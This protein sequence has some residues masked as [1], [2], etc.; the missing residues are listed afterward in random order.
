[1]QLKPGTA[2]EVVTKFPFG[3]LVATPNAL[4]NIPNEEILLSINRHVRGDWGTLDAEDWQSNDRALAHGG[5]LFSAYLSTAGVKFW[6]ITEAD[7]SVTT[8][9]LPED[10]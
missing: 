10:Y 9:L 1:M 3:E 7:R 8:V 2:D 4:Q 5:R 6:I